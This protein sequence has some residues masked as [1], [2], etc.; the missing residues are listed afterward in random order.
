MVDFTSGFTIFNWLLVF[1]A[2]AILFVIFYL[3][4]AFMIWRQTQLMT[5]ALPTMVAP[6]LKFFAFFQMGVALAFLFI[7]IGGF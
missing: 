6:F 1:K 7:V 5:R 2:F 4:F 3:V